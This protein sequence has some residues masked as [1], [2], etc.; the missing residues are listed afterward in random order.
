MMGPLLMMK[1]E[2]LDSMNASPEE[3][4]PVLKDM[5]GTLIQFLQS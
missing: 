2:Q 3:E 4:D 5:I 1:I